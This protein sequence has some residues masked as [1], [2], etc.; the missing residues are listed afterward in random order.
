M[1][2][3]SERSEQSYMMQEKS[4]DNSLQIIQNNFSKPQGKSNN[5]NQKHPQ[6]R[7]VFGQQRDTIK[8]YSPSMGLHNKLNN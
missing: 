6:Q 3:E 2:S 8:Q 4:V 1:I 5:T 7:K